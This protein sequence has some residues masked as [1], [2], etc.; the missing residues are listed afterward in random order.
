MIFHINFESSKY[1]NNGIE[2][3]LT[4]WSLKVFD[5]NG[6]SL[7]IA[8]DDTVS[9]APK[10]LMIFV[11]EEIIKYIEIETNR[12]GQL[13]IEQFCSSFEVETNESP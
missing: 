9:L 11:T 7:G 4:G 2:T 5:F 10:S 12:Y 3:L 8:S 6:I 1:S 13:I